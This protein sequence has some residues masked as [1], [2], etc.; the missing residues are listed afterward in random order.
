[1]MIDLA[2]GE[3]A[4]GAL[5]AAQ[6]QGLITNQPHTVLALSL[7]AEIGKIAPLA[8]SLE[9]RQ[10]ALASLFADFPG[11]AEA[12]WQGNLATITHLETASVTAEPVRVWV[13]A[14]NPMEVCGLYF[15]CHWL[16]DSP[17][18]FSVVWVP[19]WIERQDRLVEVHGVGEIAPTEL[20]ALLKYETPLEP[21]QRS[22]YAELWEKLGRENAPLR[23]VLNGSVTSVPAD[24]YDFALRAHLPAAEEVSV[25]QVIGRVLNQ[26]AGANDR[27]L[28]LRLQSMIRSGALSEVA[29]PSADS[30]Y[31]GRI[32]R[33][34]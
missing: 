11:V 18:L 17:C 8:A 10:T 1:M 20:P 25:A 5:K 3:S 6:H 4:A 23:V 22:L 33:A 2:F 30:P 31:S 7:Y 32:C 12:I 19:E 24:F 13:R 16:K 14:S 28:Y 15:L 9:L 26:I 21:T 29:A 34:E 27:W